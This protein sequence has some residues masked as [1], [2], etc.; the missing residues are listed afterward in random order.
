MDNIPT[1][2]KMSANIFTRTSSTIRIEELF[3]ELRHVVF[4][5]YIQSVSKEEGRN[6]LVALLHTANKS[7]IYH[8]ANSIFH[9]THTFILT[10]IYN[11][12]NSKLPESI[13]HRIND[14]E[15][16]FT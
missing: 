10:S 15:I 4:T 16:K 5:F 7:G 3:P 14:L 2:D 11:V 1:N 9:G 8:E 6:L 13:R 12:V